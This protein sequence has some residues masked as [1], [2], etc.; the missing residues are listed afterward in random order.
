MFIEI[1]FT[2]ICALLQPPHNSCHQVEVRTSG[3]RR[4]VA[5]AA[6]ELHDD[7]LLYVNDEND[8]T[9]LEAAMG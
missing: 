8:D 4:N 2:S 1:F 5:A 9:V 7:I 3:D 6:A